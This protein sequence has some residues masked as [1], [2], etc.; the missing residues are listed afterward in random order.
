MNR[1][2]NRYVEDAG[3]SFAIYC[4]TNDLNDAE[5]QVLAE[6]IY[7]WMCETVDQRSQQE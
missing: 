7:D 4:D 2:D 3:V 5:A 6:A 1:D